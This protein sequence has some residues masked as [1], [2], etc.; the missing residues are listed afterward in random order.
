MVAGDVVNTAL[1]TL[2]A[3]FDRLGPIPV[4]QIDLREPICARRHHH[5]A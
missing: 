2:D 4:S 5:H 3:D 1:A